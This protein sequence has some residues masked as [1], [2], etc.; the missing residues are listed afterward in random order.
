MTGELQRAVDRSSVGV[1]DL[2]LGRVFDYFGTEEHG[3]WR[4]C[5]LAGAYWTASALRGPGLPLPPLPDGDSQ[6]AIGSGGGSPPERE[7]QR[8]EASP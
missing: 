5:V 6:G 2:K 1:P 3:G 7:G 4:V 8:L